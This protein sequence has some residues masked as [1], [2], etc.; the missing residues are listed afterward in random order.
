MKYGMFKEPD[1]EYFNSGALG[2]THIK[3]YA[4]S[5]YG[6]YQKHIVKNSHFQKSKTP[7]MEFG[8]IVDFLITEEYDEL[9][10]GEGVVVIPE[11]FA[12]KTGVSKKKDAQEWLLEQGTKIVVTK[13]VF[14]K[15]LFIADRLIS[16]SEIDELYKKG[17]HQ[18]VARAVDETFLDVQAK[19]DCCALEDKIIVDT[20][21]TANLDKFKWVARE[22]RYDLQDV[23]YSH[24]FELNEG[25]LPNEF[26]FAV[27]EVNAPFRTQLFD[28]THFFKD[29]V[30][31]REYLDI[32][33]NISAENYEDVQSTK[34]ILRW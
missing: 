28:G 25:C 18:L 33:K 30:L 14:D 11:E 31:Q 17:Q 21:T 34:K 4:K 7:A 10:E 5:P 13:L 12:T 16:N 1:I 24:C 26:L 23:H 6:Y 29:P 15:A 32:K 27:V 9:F 20:K 22:F 19:F 2:S 8:S 3:D